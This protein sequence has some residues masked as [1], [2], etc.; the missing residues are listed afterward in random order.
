MKK[1][2]LF[3]ISAIL[4]LSLTAFGRDLLDLY[5]LGHFVEQSTAA[6]EAN[7][8]RWP[9]LS[10]VCTVC[11]GV[12][13]NSQ[14]QGYP[15]LAGQP[16]PYVAAQLRNFASGQRTNPNM[17]PLAMTMSEA[18][19]TLLSNHFAKQPVGENRAFEVEP[20]LRE[21][22]KQLVTAGGCTGCHGEQLMGHDQFPRL[23]SQGRDYLVAQ[24][25]AFAA[26]TRTEPTGV[27]K[28]VAAAASPDERKAIASYLASLV[29]QNPASPKGHQE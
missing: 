20:G 25:D 28:N 5:R 21:K 10:D 7:G 6:Y 1:L 11:H 12:N 13:G 26:G 23:A 16:A 22:G 4:A 29:P 17:G 8:G 9:Q 24:L 18:E 14:H 19:I 3:G 27:M 2:V 15:S